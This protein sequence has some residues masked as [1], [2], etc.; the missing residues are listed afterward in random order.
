MP[1]ASSIYLFY[2]G[3]RDFYIFVVDFLI[4]VIM[5]SDFIPIYR[6]AIRRL[7]SCQSKVVENYIAYG[8][9]LF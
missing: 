7:I 8:K 6:L 5:G 9:F 2:L 3:A 4:E 1:Y